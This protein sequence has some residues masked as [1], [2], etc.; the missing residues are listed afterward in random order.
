MKS[1]SLTL[2]ALALTW[3]LPSKVFARDLVFGIG[4]PK[5][6]ILWPK[7]QEFMLRFAERTDK[8]LHIELRSTPFLRLQEQVN[9]GE[10]DGDLGRLKEVYEVNSSAVRVSEPTSMLRL[11]FIY[12]KEKE[13]NDLGAIRQHKTLAS[14]DNLF[15]KRACQ[16]LKLN[17]EFVGPGSSSMDMLRLKRVASVITTQYQSAEHFRLSNDPQIFRLSEKSYYMEPIYLFLSKKNADLA[18]K[19]SSALKE[20]KQDGTYKR[21]FEMDP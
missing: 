11:F 1:W 21:I 18:D 17:C 15:H 7:L 5:E 10:L 9:K 20:L 8:D 13:F 4:L 14:K 3:T 2:F 12:N 6:H 16:A 19:F